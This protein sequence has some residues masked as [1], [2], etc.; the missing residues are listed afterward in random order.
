M[1]RL[2]RTRIPASRSTV[3]SAGRPTKVGRSWA[4][5]A[6][7]PRLSQPRSR[8]SVWGRSIRPSRGRTRRTSSMCFRGANGTSLDAALHR[9]SGLRRSHGLGHAERDSDGLARHWRGS[10]SPDAGARGAADAGAATDAASTRIVDSGHEG[11]SDASAVATVDAGPRAVANAGEL[12]DADARFDARDVQRLEPQSGVDAAAGDGPE[13]PASGALAVFDG[14]S[15]E[16]ED[17]WATAIIVLLSRRSRSF[18]AARDPVRAS[19]FRVTL[20]RFNIL[21]ERRRNL[22]SQSLFGPEPRCRW[23]CPFAWR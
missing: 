12:S 7:L 2:S 15:R 10:R 4:E 21:C 14:G 9:G 13:T 3:P 11:G 1:C 22:R 18:G 17:S 19:R 23:T 5:R 6:R 20:T 8:S 16:V